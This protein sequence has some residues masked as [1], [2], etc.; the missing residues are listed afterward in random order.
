M[1]SSSGIVT[2]DNAAKY[3][4]AFYNCESNQC[5][6]AYRANLATFFNYA[7]G[8]WLSRAKQ[9]VLG[10]VVLY[11]APSNTTFSF[12]TGLTQLDG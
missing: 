7:S 5:R 1:N 12:F 10:D 3:H 6:Y 9:F 2:Y 8:G 11:V 4:G